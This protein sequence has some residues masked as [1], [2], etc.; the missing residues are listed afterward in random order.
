MF[1]KQ[2][3]KSSPLQGGAAKFETII[4][5]NALLEGHLRIKESARIDGKVIGDILAA[6]DQ[7]ILVVVVE[8]G[9]VK[10]NIQA[11]V[12]VVAGKVIGNI[13]AFERLELHAQCRVEG[14]IRYASL[15][16]EHGATV[17]GLL[18]HTDDKKTAA[19]AAMTQKTLERAAK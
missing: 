4:G 5:P 14:D 19:V 13:Q 2:R 18:L 12:V 16:M 10:G 1:G 9:E 3:Q 8:N 11:N 7:T 17:L 15:A 6:A